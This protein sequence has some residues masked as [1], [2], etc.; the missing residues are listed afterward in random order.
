MPEVNKKQANVFAGQT[1]AAN[2]RA[3]RR[4]SHRA[5]RKTRLGFSGLRTSW[6]G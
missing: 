2:E 4:I 1:H 5:R 6:N 3:P